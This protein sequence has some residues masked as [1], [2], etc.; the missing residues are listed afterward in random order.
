[1][2]GI[3]LNQTDLPDPLARTLEQMV[4]RI[5]TLE[6]EIESLKKQVKEASGT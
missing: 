6:E 5:H 4:E 2:G 1:V 3:D